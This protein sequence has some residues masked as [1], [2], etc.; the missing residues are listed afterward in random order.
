MSTIKKIKSFLFENK[1]TKQT[2]AKNTAWLS[3]SNFGGRL[4]KAIIIIYAAR[5]LGAAGYGVFSYAVTLAGFF[6]L[7]TDPGV[8][9]ILI[10]EGSKASLEEQRLLFS[11]S[12]L[13][14]TVFVGLSVMLV[15]FVAPL[16]S[17]LPGAR[18]LIPLVALIILFDSIRELFSSFFRMQ[19]KMQWDAAA[20]LLA[21]IGIA[22]IGFIFININPSPI[23]FGWAYV[24]GTMLGAIAAI[25][26]MRHNIKHLFVHVPWSRL[27]SILSAAWPFAIMGALGIL[28]TNTDII[29]ISWMKTATDVGV[30][31]AAIRIIQVLY[32]IPMIIQ[33]STLPVFARFAGKNN[34]VFRQG[35]EK[36]LGLIFLISIPLSLGG[37]ILGT[38]IMQFVFGTP[39]AIGGLA[40]SILMLGLFFDYAAGVISNAIFAY[41][42]QKSLIASSAIG[43]TANIVL[44]VILIPIFGIAGSAIATLIAQILSNTYLWYAMKR[45]NPFSVL[46]H[47]KKIFASGIVMAAITITLALLHVNVIINIAISGSVYCVM[48][49]ALRENLL[50]EMKNIL[51]GEKAEAV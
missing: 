33:M 51:F 40:F 3:I 11:A 48:L 37:A 1:T 44:D 47:V 23:Y 38:S 25:W 27:K 5:V 42:H 15:L 17:T 45:I 20:F 9:A 29:I 14:K 18:E 50:F 41:N 8:G 12:F 10:R 31:S 49:L 24:I 28:F 16:F 34:V 46:P 13:L 4:F 2:I 6:T 26:F 36:T 7:F 39:Y 35:L 22:I 32:V 43:G 21:N 30:Y 19:E